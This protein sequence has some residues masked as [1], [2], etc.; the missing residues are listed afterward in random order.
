[1]FGHDARVL[2]L[3]DNISVCLAFDRSGARNYALLR[4]IRRFS[5]YCLSRILSMSVRWV[6]SEL[7]NADE[8]SRVHSDE[9]SK[10]LAYVIPAVRWAK[11]HIHPEATGSGAAESDPQA[12]F[13]EEA[14]GRD[15]YQQVIQEVGA[16]RA[17]SA[18]ADLDHNRTLQPTRCTCGT[19]GVQRSSEGGGLAVQH[20]L[21]SKCPS[22]EGSS[23]GASPTHPATGAYSC[24]SHS[25]GEPA[26]TSGEQRSCSNYLQAVRQGALGLQRLCGAPGPL[27]GAGGQPRH[28]PPG[29]PQPFV[30]GGTS[31]LQG[32]SSFGGHLISLPGLRSDGRQED[33]SVMEGIERILEI[34]S[35]AQSNGLPAGRMGRSGGGVDEKEAAE[36]GAILPRSPEQLCTA[37]R[38]LEGEGVL[39]SS[40]RKRGHE[41]V[42]A[43][44]EPR[45]G[46]SSSENRGLRYFRNDGLT[47]ASRLVRRT[48][49]L[50]E[51]VP[52]HAVSVGLHLRA[53][54]RGI[55]RH[56]RDLRL[57]NHAVSNPA[58]G[59]IHRP[60]S[61]SPVAAGNS[62]EGALEGVQICDQIRK[63]G[64]LAKT[65]EGLPPRFRT[66]A[67]V[68]ERELGAILLGRTSA[69]R[70][71]GTAT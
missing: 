35:G 27:H 62:K 69:P 67:L 41:S 49:C 34:H 65:W 22:E 17:R 25:G 54:Q 29:I 24:E 36:N 23:S 59:P 28:P 2:L 39:L 52:P 43:S 10:S 7:N 18:P 57:H 50:A 8:P 4:Q 60:V 70:F 32:R 53:V 44:P 71:T 14:G 48:L 42:V 56:L 11:T 19:S 45:R 3:T 13:S 58:F 26:H 21:D 5:A 15:Q 66:H 55:Q 30:P 12:S 33:T 31:E 68:Y 37:F 6:P 63:V 38:T 20:Q 40:A 1:M 51:A 9:A 64:W 46:G 47:V 61:Q 16:H